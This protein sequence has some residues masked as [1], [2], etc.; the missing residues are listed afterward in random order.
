MNEWTVKVQDV[1]DYKEPELFS[2]DPHLNTIIP[3]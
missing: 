2:I 1:Y 3:N